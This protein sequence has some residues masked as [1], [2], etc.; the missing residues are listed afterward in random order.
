[1]GDPMGCLLAE[2]VEPIPFPDELHRIAAAADEDWTRAGEVRE[3]TFE[4]S[5]QLLVAEEAST[6]FDDRGRGRIHGVEN[7]GERRLGCNALARSAG[8]PGPRRE[9]RHRRARGGRAQGVLR[10]SSKRARSVGGSARACA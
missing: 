10:A 4:A 7:Y 3:E 8:G 5:G 6:H 9:G 1:Q 2:S